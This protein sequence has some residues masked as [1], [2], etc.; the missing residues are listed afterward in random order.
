M[1]IKCNIIIVLALIFAGC[2]YGQD[3]PKLLNRKISISID[4][5]SIEQTFN[6][7]GQSSG[8]H[9]AYNAQLL[10]AD[11]LITYSCQQKKIQNVVHDI[12]GLN[13]GF[14]TNGNHIVIVKNIPV[15]K[16]KKYKVKGV[17]FDKLTNSPIK[18]A[19]VYDIRQKSFTRSDS[20]G[21]FNYTILTEDA[22]IILAIRSQTY[23]D[24]IITIY[25]NKGMS[26]NVGLSKFEAIPSLPKLG[27]QNKSYLKD[28]IVGSYPYYSPVDG[29]SIVDI[30]VSD[31]RQKMAV[32]LSPLGSVS[33][34]FQLSLVPS[35][36]TNNLYSS[37]SKTSLAINL[38][39]GYGNTVEGLEI[40]GFLNIR[41]EDV[42]GVQL[43]GFQNIVGGKLMGIQMAGFGNIVHG[44]SIGI[45]GAGFY[46]INKDHSTGVQV[47]GFANFSEEFDGL[48]VAGFLNRSITNYGQIAGFA[49]INKERSTSLQVSGGFNKTGDM[50][51]TQIAG[52]F[53]ISKSTSFG[54]IGGLFNISKDSCKLW[55]VS[56]IFNSAKYSKAIQIGLFNYAD[57]AERISIGLISF[58]RKGYHA[59]DISAGSL[60]HLKMSFKTGSTHKLYN[61]INLSKNFNHNIYCVGY[62]LGMTSESEKRFNLGAEVIAQFIMNNEYK[63]FENEYLFQ[64]RF[65]PQFRISRL[66]SIFLSANYSL[67]VYENEPSS[68]I[69]NDFKPQE[70]D[71]NVQALWTGDFGFRLRF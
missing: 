31:L 20:R 17:I 61:L 53:N 9:F 21:K 45:Q 34:R 1:S 64:F 50:Q 52:L 14:K 4:Q 18:S 26:L 49:N 60:Q 10:P 41:R 44:P 32:D 5:K 19:I 30:F 37:V 63:I 25:G 69:F 46:N 40:G 55:Q 23:Q 39:S 70:I 54:Q 43:A 57:T 67:L 48:Q 47:A 56:S 51:G 15:D 24:T 22:S 28:S 29:M 7:I 12:L 16:R 65:Q 62:G 68:P 36:S 3:N 71:E 13:Y 2:V 33:S 38:I 8:I 35:I 59:L 6:A 11:S 66:V 27:G 58:A 42:Y